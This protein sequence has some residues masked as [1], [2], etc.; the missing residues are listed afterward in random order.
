[1]VAALVCDLGLQSTKRKSNLRRLWVGGGSRRSAAFPEEVDRHAGEHD[2]E[3]GPGSLRFVEQQHQQ[4]GAGDRDVERGDYRVAEGT[5]GPLGVGPFAA[6]DEQA[7]DGQYVKDQHGKDDVVEQ[8]AVEVAVLFTAGEA[9]EHG[10]TRR[11]AQPG[12]RQHE[13]TSPDALQGQPEARHVA[14]VE[15]AGGPEEQA[16]AS[17]RIIDA[18]TRQDQPVVAAEGG[19]HDRDGHDD[20]TSTAED[21]FNGSG[22]HAVIRGILD[23]VERQ[24]AEIGDMGQQVEDR[25]EAGAR[26]EREG[27]IAARI[28]YLAGGE[29]DVVPGVGGTERADLGYAKGDEEAECAPGGGDSSDEGQVWFDGRHAA[30]RPEVVEVNFDGI[31]VAREEQPNEDQR[32]EG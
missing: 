29:S 16:V 2:Q 9:V 20:S 3:A 14:V 26:R 5:V 7:K 31:R 22:G 15:L 24:Q 23:L 25:D 28:L 12:A 19:D 4:D 10:C 18:R 32:E 27:D 17:H 13:Q 1:M 21:R 30:R 11:I 6:E 8:V